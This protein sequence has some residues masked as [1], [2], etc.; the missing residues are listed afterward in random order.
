MSDQATIETKLDE[1]QAALNALPGES[2]VLDLARDR[3]GQIRSFVRSHIGIEEGRALQAAM[4]QKLAAD[5][6][7]AAGV[8]G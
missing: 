7:A 2:P 4:D 3:V 8:Q 5:E 6:A 1:L